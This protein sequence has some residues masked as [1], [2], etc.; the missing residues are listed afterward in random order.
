MNREI[1]S[2]NVRVINEEGQ[3]LGVI[4]L[5]EA[6]AHAE[7]AGLDLVEVSASADPPVCKIMDYGKFRYKQSKKIH[8]ARKS[9]T[10]IHVKEI[11][12][13][14]K[15]EAHDLQVKIK[16]IKK[17][18]EQKDK[19]KI[20]MIFRGREIAFTEI[21]RKIME[22]IKTALADE[23]VMDQEPRLEGRSMVMIVSPKK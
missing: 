21:G 15:T 18:L 4:P 13:R 8:D 22:Q 3:P 17:F 14:P 11:R 7:R 19:V 9:Q 2:A 5:E 23:C 16:H 12:L 10:V 6:M 1:R 20:S